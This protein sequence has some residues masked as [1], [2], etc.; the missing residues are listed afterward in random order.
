MVAFI[1]ALES[2]GRGSFILG[3]LGTCTRK[4]VA[5]VRSHPLIGMTRPLK[6][7]AGLI[8]H[9]AARAVGVGRAYPVTCLV[10][11]DVRLPGGETRTFVVVLG[12][13][14]GPSVMVATAGAQRG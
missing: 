6:A 13:R 1:V 3:S 8:H 7:A 14:D 5:R 10:V 12:W 2:R 9:D 11:E 4:S